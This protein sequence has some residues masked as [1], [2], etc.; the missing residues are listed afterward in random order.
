MLLGEDR[1]A[2]QA[3]IGNKEWPPA[4]V[5]LITI[6]AKGIQFNL[7]VSKKDR[8]RLDKVSGPE[9]VGS[10]PFVG[11]YCGRGTPLIER[12]KH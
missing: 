6:P 2:M 11:F 1:K 8:R 7:H 10:R 4:K 9:F 5:R 12:K 3:V